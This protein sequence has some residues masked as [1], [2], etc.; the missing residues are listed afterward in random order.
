MSDALVLQYGIKP[1]HRFDERAGASTDRSP[2][3]RQI[4]T[5]ITK[6]FV[7][8]DYAGTKD[9][10]RRREVGFGPSRRGGNAKGGSI[11]A[12]LFLELQSVVGTALLH[13]WVS[14]PERHAGR[15]HVRKCEPR[16]NIKGPCNHHCKVPSPFCG[17]KGIRTPETLL[18]FTRF[19]GGP[20]QP[21]LHLSFCRANI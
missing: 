1:S 13:R 14:T 6:Q 9:D 20:V 8:L 7:G 18:R 3:K 21:L 12:D 16:N 15:H 10:C 5:G 17:K 11:E 4:Q 2:V 19:P